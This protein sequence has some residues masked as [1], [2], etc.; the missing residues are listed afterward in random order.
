MGTVHVTFTLLCDWQGVPPVY[1][2]Y[3]DN[4]LVTE[5]TYRFKN[6]ELTIEEC[7]PL[8]IPAGPHYMHVVNVYPERGTFKVTDFKVNEKP[9]D[10]RERDSRFVLNL[11]DLKV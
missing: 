11:D 1:R 2:L 10:Y 9:R 6:T 3:I 4:E 5:R 8:N 7:I